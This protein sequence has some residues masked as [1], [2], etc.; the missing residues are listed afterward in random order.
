MISVRLRF[1]A[2]SV[3]AAVLASI[4][5]MGGPGPFRGPECLR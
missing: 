5:L 4:I 2:G 3:G 1:V